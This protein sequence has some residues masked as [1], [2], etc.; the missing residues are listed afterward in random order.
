MTR[1]ERAEQL[2]GIYAIV[3]HDARDVVATARAAMDNGVKIVQYR[4]KGAL[5]VETVFALRKLARARGALLILND[6]WR[7]VRA[8][9]CDGVHLGE[10][11][12]DFSELGAMRALLGERIL[13]V[14]CGNEAEVGRIDARAVDYLGVGSVYA[15]VSKAD[16]GEPIGI[17]GLRR[18]A[19]ATALPVAA[20]GGINGTNIAEVRRSGVA[21]AAVIS[22][23]SGAPEP[24]AAA[25]ALVEAWRA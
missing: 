3:N 7:A 9:D 19:T 12:I 17:A 13:G 8:L 14:S 24:A 1:S 15:T 5:S 4:A 21:M 20:I 2:H 25:R 16:A 10:D 23:I 11:D 6:E 18:V 22:A